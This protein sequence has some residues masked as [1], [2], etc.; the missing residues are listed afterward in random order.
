MAVIQDCLFSS[1][2]STHIDLY[3]NTHDSRH[4]EICLSLRIIT[5]IQNRLLKVGSCSAGLL[6]QEDELE[7][8]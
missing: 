1:I 7:A 5:A 6:E 3:A 2:R 4:I 8:D